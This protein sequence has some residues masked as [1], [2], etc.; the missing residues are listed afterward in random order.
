MARLEMDAVGAD[1]QARTGED[2][3]GVEGCG[4]VWTDTA[5]KDWTNVDCNGE[6]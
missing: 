5:G 3:M 6:E 2:G 4:L 1:R